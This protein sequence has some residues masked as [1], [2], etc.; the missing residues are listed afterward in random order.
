MP[1]RGD[2]PGLSQRPPHLSGGPRPR[3]PGQGAALAR[4]LSVRPWDDQP[5]PTAQNFFTQELDNLSLPAGAG[6]TVQTTRAGGGAI[7][8]PYNNVAVI[9]AVTFFCSA[10]TT[11][12]NIIYTVRQNQSPI[13]GLTNLKFA[14]RVAGFIEFGVGGTWDIAPGAFLDVLITNR[15]AFGP[16]L[17]NFTM[18]G[19][20]CS[21]PDI[22]AW[23]GQYPG[24]LG[25]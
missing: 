13:R 3:D 14:P 12:T 1:E 2:F 15:N 7:Q 21:V 22:K 17:V 10:P 16:W 18:T 19:W 11:D 4:N 8:I 20:F 24:Q 5:I 9:G 6:S 23:T 25:T